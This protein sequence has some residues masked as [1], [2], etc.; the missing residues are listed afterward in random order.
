M[1]PIVLHVAAEVSPFHKSGGLGD[2]LAGLPPA[3]ADQDL[4]VRIITPRYG[5][6]SKF[7]SVGGPE[8]LIPWPQT[9]PIHL[10]GRTHEA[11][12]YEAKTHRGTATTYFVE[13]EH[14]SRGGIYGYGDDAYRFAIFCKA[15]LT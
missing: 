12:I 13:A 5:T 9:L 3:L 10:A 14:L 8:G 7:G 15:A 4:D 6:A 1:K 2:V 11:R